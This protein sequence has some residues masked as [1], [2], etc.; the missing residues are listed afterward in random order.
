MIAKRF[1]GM[2][3]DVCFMAGLLHDVGKLI[4]V[5]NLADDYADVLSLAKSEGCSIQEAERRVLDT[6]HAEV[7]AWMAER[8]QLPAELVDAIRL[9]HAENTNDLP[10]SRIVTCVRAANLCAQFPMETAM[11]EDL[12]KNLGLNESRLKEIAAELELRT[13]EIDQFLS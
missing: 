1:G 13:R 5:A 11:P 2:P 8:W 6:D 4:L 3:D 10:H 7:G 9:H 12:A